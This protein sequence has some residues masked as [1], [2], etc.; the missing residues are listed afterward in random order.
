MLDKTDSV[1]GL[2]ALL[3]A[4]GFTVDPANATEI[5]R[6]LQ[7]ISMIQTAT[8]AVENI[9][10]VVHPKT[11]ATRSICDMVNPEIYLVVAIADYPGYTVKVA[12]I[13]VAPGTA[14]K[15]A[16]MDFDLDALMS[17]S[18][19]PVPTVAMVSE[20]AVCSSSRRRRTR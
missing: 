7:A 1:I 13:L 20:T 6:E 14:I 19:T 15:A 12:A 4:A 17:F 5:K 16:N 8:L 10:A 9:I 2:D 11:G 18:T 3:P